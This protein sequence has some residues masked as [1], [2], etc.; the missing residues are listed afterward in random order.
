M[1]FNRWV[2]FGGFGC[3]LVSSRGGGSGRELSGGRDGGVRVG[4]VLVEGLHGREENDLTN[5]LVISEHHAEAVNTHTPTGGGRE[6]HLESLAEDVINELSLVISS[7]LGGSLLL[8]E[9]TLDVGVVQLSVSIAELASSA[10]KLETLGEMRGVTMPLGEGRH[11]LRVIH[12][13]GGGDAL[14]LNELTDELIEETVSGLGRRALNV[15]L[16]AKLLEEDGGGLSSEIGGEGDLELLLKSGHHG[17]AAPGRGEVNLDG[18]SLGTVQVVLDLVASSDLLDEARHQI[19]S[20]LEQVIVIGVG[21]VELAGSELGVVSHVDTFVSELA[22]NLV[23]ALN[24][25][26]DELLE[27]KLGSD[28]HE[29]IEMES[30][31]MGDEGLGGGSSGDHVHHGG[32]NLQ[33]STLVQETANSRDDLAADNKVVANVGVH[34]QVQE[35]LTV[36]SLLISELTLSRQHVQAGGQKSHLQGDDGQ[37]T[38]LRAG[39]ISTDANNISTTENGGDLQESINSTFVVSGV[40]QNLELITLTDDIDEVELS[41]GSSE[42]TDASYLSVFQRKRIYAKEGNSRVSI[43]F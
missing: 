43:A 10:E 30:V 24:T 16:S 31:V 15:E 8:E 19:F 6:T 27:E 35:T 38:S 37:L 21:H 23:D 32:L 39:G 22:T 18:L 11:D 2:I 26:N 4:L 42:L 7:S 41:R 28:T 33:E 20:H 29:E 17:D 14:R 40:G 25:S 12:D 5:V 34:N 1:V 36:T 9:R 13:E 3:C